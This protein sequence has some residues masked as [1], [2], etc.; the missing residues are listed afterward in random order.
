MVKHFWNEQPTTPRCKT[1]STEQ[2]LN[3]PEVQYQTSGLTAVDYPIK[4]LQRH[5]QGPRKVKNQ[6]G[7]DVTRRSSKTCPEGVKRLVRPSSVYF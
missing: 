1:R 2:T 7:T 4:H 5:V 6:Q 3:E